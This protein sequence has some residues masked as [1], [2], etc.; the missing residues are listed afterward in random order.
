MDLSDR[1]ATLSIKLAIGWFALSTCV[2]AYS[3]LTLGFGWNV[4]NVI[5]PGLALVGLVY[6]YPWGR[7]FVLCL[8]L[9]QVAL[10]A[11]NATMLIVIATKGLYR[12][13]VVIPSKGLAPPP[14]WYFVVMSILAILFVILFVGFLAWMAVDLFRNERVKR[15]FISSKDLAMKDST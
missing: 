1:Q 15:Y 6:R 3:L 5:I 9:V 10:L 8:L 14:E 12:D 4:M 2:A 11:P 13:L 7:F